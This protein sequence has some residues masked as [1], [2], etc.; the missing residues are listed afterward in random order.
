M[1]YLLAFDKHFNLVLDKVDE[2]WH[3][4]IKVNQ[5]PLLIGKLSQPNFFKNLTPEHFETLTDFKMVVS[6]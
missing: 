2:V 5:S 1:A 3:R 4:S 6:L